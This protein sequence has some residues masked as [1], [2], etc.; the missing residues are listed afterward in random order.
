MKTNCKGEDMAEAES[1][2]MNHEYWNPTFSI[3]TCQVCHETILIDLVQPAIRKYDR[4]C[5]DCIKELTKT[6]ESTK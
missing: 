1:E 3:D 6:K 5:E 4:I 2:Y